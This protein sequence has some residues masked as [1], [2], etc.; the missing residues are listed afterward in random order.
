MACCYVQE[1]LVTGL[2]Y[3]HK[4]NIAQRDLKPGNTLV[5]NQRTALRMGIWP[6]SISSALSANLQILVSVD[7]RK[8]KQ[9]HFCRRKYSMPEMEALNKLPSS[10]YSQISLGDVLLAK[11]NFRI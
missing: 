2:E 7:L 8:C 4:H 10:R 1:I 6:N 5:S 9:P 11:V 3:L